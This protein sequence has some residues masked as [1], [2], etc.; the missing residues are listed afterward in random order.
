[1]NDVEF[2]YQ[3]KQYFQSIPLR[4]IEVDPNTDTDPNNPIPSIHEIVIKNNTPNTL[5]EFL[6]DTNLPK[7]TFEIE[8]LPDRI[9]PNG[10][11]PMRLAIFGRR[12]FEMR[13]SIPEE[14]KLDILYKE[15]MVRL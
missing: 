12:I 13:E 11:K 1:M 4:E 9:P 14:I 10:S 6:V 3:D 15:R 5:T 8:S 2:I 7:G